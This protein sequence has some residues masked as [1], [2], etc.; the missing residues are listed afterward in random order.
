MLAQGDRNSDRSCRAEADAVVDAWFRQSTRTRRSADAR[1]TSAFLALLIPPRPAPPRR[2]SA[3]PEPQKGTWP[4]FNKMIGGYFK[5]HW[6]DRRDPREDRRPEEPAD[7]KFKGQGFGVH[8][9]TY[10]MGANSFSRDERARAD[11]H[12]HAGMSAADRALEDHP[13]ADHDYALS[14]IKREGQG[15]VF[16][17]AHGHSESI[18]AMKPMLEH[19]LAGMQYAIGDL[20][21]DDS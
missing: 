13:R 3:G 16:Y 11:E 14:W 2:R 10:T 6:L 5:F 8:D 20:K 4:E 21:A 9:E 15:R 19:L 1:P 12:R 18:Y 17:K 7:S